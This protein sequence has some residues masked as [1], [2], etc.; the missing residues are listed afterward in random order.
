MKIPGLWITYQ[1]GVDKPIGKWLLE[2]EGIGPRT[3][4]CFLGEAENLDRFDTN[5][6]LARYAG[7]GAVIDQSG[8]S[9]G[10][11]WDAHRRKIFTRNCRELTSMVFYIK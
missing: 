10:H 3:A 4:G 9:N 5:A 1:P 2:Q 8:Q 6:Q 11:H 7:A